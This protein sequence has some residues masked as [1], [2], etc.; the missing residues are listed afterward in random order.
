MK[1]LI[2]FDLDGVITSEESYWD[3]A[4][5]TLHELLY[6]PRYW[7]LASDSDYRVATSASESRSLSR[8]T[9]PSWLIFSF[10]ARSLNSNWDTCYATVCLHLI[11]LLAQLPRS[12]LLQPLQPWDASWLTALREQVTTLRESWP[13][14]CATLHQTWLS[15]HPFD[16]PIFQGAVGLELLE[17]LDAFASTSLGY[18]VNGVFSR[19]ERFWRFCQDIFQEWLLGDTL[20]TR[21]Y[22][23]APT[24]PGKPGCIFFEEPLLPPDEVRQTLALLTTRGYVLGIASGRVAQEAALPLAKYD[25]LRYFDEHH[26][27]TY[28]AVLWGEETLHQR[29]P[30]ALG[31]PHPF[32]FWAAIDRTE[33]LAIMTGTQPGPSHTPFIVV[34]DSTSD[35][36]GGRAAG[37]LTIAVL[38]GSHSPEARELLLRSQPDLVIDDITLLPALLSRLDALTTIQQLQFTQ[39]ETA[40]QLLRLWFARHMD[41]STERVQ[42]IPRAVSLNSFNG[43]YQSAGAEFFFKTHVEEHG[44]LHEYYHA[45]QLEQAGYNVVQPL[46]LVHERERQMVIYPVIKWPVMFDLLRAQET[47]QPLP[48]GLDAALLVAAERQSCQQLLAIYEQTFEPAQ[49]SSGAPVHQ[50]FWHR[51]VGRFQE[52]YLGKML[53]LPASALSLPFAQVQNLHWTINGVQQPYTLAEL[54]AQ[55]RTVLH[56]ARMTATVIGHGDAHFGNVF[57]ETNK[58]PARYLYFDPAFA[59]RHSPLLDIVKPLFHNIFAMWMYFPQEIARDLQISVQL[60]SDQLAVEHNYSLTPIRRAL[61]QVKQEHLLQPLLTRL[62]ALGALPEDWSAILRLALMCCP[63]LTVN[64]FD[65]EK[66]VPQVGWLGLAQAIQLGNSGLDPWKETQ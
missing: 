64:L 37:G 19:H 66:R 3:C 39:R 27:G 16:Q 5:L 54:V 29:Q 2:L 63:L 32:H 57:L 52:F 36:L 65:Q 33:A 50:L 49:D 24:Q 14:I 38:T 34:G 23:H 53:P 58:V 44:V 59:G 17:R 28:D 60:T 8:L 12:S 47:D 55:G 18:P 43:I 20:Y 62:E 51:L 4:G 48:T 22:A 11:A 31:K 25:L 15:N 56:P 26:L 45:Q 1:N 9:F 35:I 13:E 61:L 6:S 7:Q 21:T 10:K 40:E 30:L 41:L 46:H 42:L